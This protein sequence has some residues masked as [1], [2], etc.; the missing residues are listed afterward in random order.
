MDKLTFIQVLAAVA[1]VAATWLLASR[2]QRRRHLGFR[3]FVVGNLLW[4]AWGVSVHSPTFVAL[5]ICLAAANIRGAIK[6]VES[7]ERPERYP[8]TLV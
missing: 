8:R 1:T 3:F 2:S 7:A 5:Q 6:T 4:M